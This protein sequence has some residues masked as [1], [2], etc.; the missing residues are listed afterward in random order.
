MSDLHGVVKKRMMRALAERAAKES[1]AVVVQRAAAPP[2]TVVGKL[3]V[4]EA[5]VG[6]C[7]RGGDRW[8]QVKWLGYTAPTWEPRGNLINRDRTCIVLEQYERD[9]RLR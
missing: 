9:N 3:F 1:G 7:T 6:R 4:V 5:I 8:Y 2:T